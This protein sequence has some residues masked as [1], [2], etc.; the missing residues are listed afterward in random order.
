MGPRTFEASKRATRSGCVLSC[1]RFRSA[2]LTRRPAVAVILQGRRPAG[3]R[4]RGMAAPAALRRRVLPGRMR[5]VAAE[6]RLTRAAARHAAS[7]RLAVQ[8]FRP[9]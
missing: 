2:R 1:P 7:P 5:R 6:L 8:I 9:W 3:R 4:L